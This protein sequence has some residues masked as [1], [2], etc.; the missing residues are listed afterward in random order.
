MAYASKR[1]GL[2]ANAPNRSI[3]S[4]SI[5]AHVDQGRVSRS[6]NAQCKASGL[7]ERMKA[8][9]ACVPEVKATA[10]ESDLSHIW[11]R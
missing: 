9:S 6:D 1:N 10:T 11:S 4:A 7:V 8:T 3:P 5:D 2:M